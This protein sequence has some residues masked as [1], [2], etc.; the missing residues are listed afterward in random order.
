MFKKNSTRTTTQIP[1]ILSAH[2]G[3][4]PST[5]DRN[6]KSHKHFLLLGPRKARRSWPQSRKPLDTPPRRDDGSH[7]SSSSTG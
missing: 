2:L 4:I 7:G 1:L 5:E 6:H 3:E